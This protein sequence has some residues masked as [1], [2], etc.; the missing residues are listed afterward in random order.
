[1]SRKNGLRPSQF[2]GVHM[3]DIPLIED[4]LLLNTLLYNIDTLEVNIIGKLARRIVKEHENA[5]KLLRYNSHVFYLNNIDTV[6]QSFRCPNRWHILQ[7][8]K[9][10]GTTFNYMQWSSAKCLS[11]EGI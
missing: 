7:Q 1:M 3:N 10:F 9:Q 8:N 6:F 5:V 2:Q 11:E 4:L